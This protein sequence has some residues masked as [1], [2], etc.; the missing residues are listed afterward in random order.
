L[1]TGWAV[2]CAIGSE[3]KLDALHLSTDAMIAYRIEEMC[4]IY[5]SP[6]ILSEQIAKMVSPKGFD[7]LRVIDKVVMK[8]SPLTPREIYS[9]DIRFTENIDTLPPLLLEEHDTIGGLV[10]PK[11]ALSSDSVLIPK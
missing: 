3:F 6:I 9:F 7:K 10:R 2:E 11:N 1:H 8:E 4:S 5:N